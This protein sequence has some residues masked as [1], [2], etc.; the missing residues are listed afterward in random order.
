[1]KLRIENDFKINALCEQGF[2]NT[3]KEGIYE[4]EMNNYETEKMT[5]GEF[6]KLSNKEIRGGKLYWEQHS[7]FA[8]ARK[9]NFKNKSLQFFI[10]FFIL[11]RTKREQREHMPR[12]M[13]KMVEEEKKRGSYKNNNTKEKE[14]FDAKYY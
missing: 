1:M 14:S 9:F 2:K 6:K 4:I 10:E 7:K 8:V 11:F 5:F 12:H 13:K 3:L